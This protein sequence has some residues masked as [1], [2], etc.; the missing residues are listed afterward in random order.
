MFNFMCDIMCNTVSGQEGWRDLYLDDM[1]KE[2]GGK[3]ETSSGYTSDGVTYDQSLRLKNERLEQAECCQLYF[4]KNAFD[5]DQTNIYIDGLKMC[6]HCFFVLNL[7]KF[8]KKLSLSS[9]DKNMLDKYLIEF[10]KDHNMNACK[11]TATY[12]TCLL[13]N[14]LKEEKKPEVDDKCKIYDKILI[15]N[16]PDRYILYM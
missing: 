13:C 9:A 2:Q 14:Y 5:F 16:K 10:S 12:G 7:E 6:I 11:R 3:L 1:D 8:N 4:R 15:K